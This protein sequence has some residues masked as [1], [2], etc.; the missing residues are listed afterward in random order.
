M[1]EVYVR[2]PTS[3]DLDRRRRRR[4]DRVVAT[5][6]VILL[7][8]FLRRRCRIRHVPFVSQVSGPRGGRETN[9]HEERWG[10]KRLMGTFLVVLI[11]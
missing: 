7:R 9:L 11:G 4:S 6:W 5:C 2:Q 10:T 3:T 1:A 8:N